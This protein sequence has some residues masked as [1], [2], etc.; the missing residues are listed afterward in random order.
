M[1]A[2]FVA[3]TWLWK[4]IAAAFGLRVPNLLD[5]QHDIS[6]TVTLDNRHRPGPNEAADIAAT[7]ARSWRRTT[8]TSRSS[9]S[10]TAAPTRP[11]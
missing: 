1:L 7:S 4:V 9:P 11:A 3:L 8:P 10:T 2:W 6:P 5:P